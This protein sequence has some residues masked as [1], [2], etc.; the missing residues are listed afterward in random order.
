[1]RIDSR[2]PPVCRTR[3]LAAL[4]LPAVAW[5]ASSLLVCAAVL[6]DE[7]VRELC[8]V[9]HT[10]TVADFQSHMHAEKGLDCDTCHGESVRHRTS[11]GH[12]EPDRVAAPHEVPALCGGCHPGKEATPI[13]AQYSES[14]HGK[15]VLEKSRMRSPH[16]GTCHGIH[17]V[18]AG[19]AMERQCKRCHAQ[20]PAGCS[21]VPASKTAVSCAGCHQPHRFEV[22]GR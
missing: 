18:R 20:L 1:M 17:S 19:K 22:K 21:G 11:Q 8:R 13:P 4:R 3:G 14:K 15:R 5:L 9:C 12:T 6:A 2:K 7:K 10:E 16:C